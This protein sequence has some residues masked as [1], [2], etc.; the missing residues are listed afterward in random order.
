MSVTSLIVRAADSVI[1]GYVTTKTAIANDANDN[2]VVVAQAVV[3]AFEAARSQMM[4]D[5]RDPFPTWSGTAVEI[6]ADGRPFFSVASDK[7]EIAADGIDAAT[8]TFTK[9]LAGGTTQT[10]F[11]ATVKAKIPFGEG[12]F[13]N[14]SL[15]FTSG[16]ATKAFRTTESG[17]YTLRS[18]SQFRLQ[19]PLTV[20]AY[21]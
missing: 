11:N 5:G 1:R 18:T 17:T 8:L 4:A 2:Y 10:G 12:R 9:L 14:L 6:P 3:D 21:E 19:A 16:V 13:R 15:S 7:S 20:E